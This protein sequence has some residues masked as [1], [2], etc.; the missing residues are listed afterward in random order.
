MRQTI[1]GTWIFQLVLIF[2]LIFSLSACGKEKNVDDV[3]IDK[4]SI[5]GDINENTIK[6]NPNGTVIEISCEDFSDSSVDISTLEDFV[7]SEIDNYNTEAGVSKISLVEYQEKGGLVKTAI[8]YS[9]VATFNAFNMSDMIQGLYNAGLAEDALVSEVTSSND[10]LTQNIE[11]SEINE[12]ELLE[13]GYN[14]DDI[15]S[16]VLEEAITGATITDA[17]ATLT[18]ANDLSVVE[19]SE[20]DDDSYMMVI[21]SDPAVFTINTGVIVYYSKNSELIDSSTVRVFGGDKAV[22]VYKF[23]Y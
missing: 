18:D 1:G 12:E 2:T 19:A 10:A 4:T 3:V 5:I 17:V 20:I 6:L 22:I 23:Y 16:G 11:V 7:N 8:Q 14:L 21:T 9:D 15:E 13:A